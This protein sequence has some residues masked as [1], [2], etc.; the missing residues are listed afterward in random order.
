MDQ[1]TGGSGN[2]TTVDERGS[3]RRICSLAARQSVRLRSSRTASGTCANQRRF[4]TPLEG[5]CN[6]E[7]NSDRGLRPRAGRSGRR[8]CVH[9]RPG[10]RLGVESPGGAAH[11]GGSVSR[12]DG[13]LRVPEP[14]QAEHR[15]AARERDSRR[16][17]RCGPELVHV[18]ARRAVQHQDRHGRRREAER[19]LPL[20]VRSGRRARTSSATPLSRSR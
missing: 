6:E 8:R 11:R 13:P 9:D 1:V 15:H 3:H 12:P 18:L 20:P 2:A 5:E 16:G 19:D 7:S 4:E 10:R 17:P 14:R